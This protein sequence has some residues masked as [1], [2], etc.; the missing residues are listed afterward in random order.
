MLTQTR[1]DANNDSRISVR[2]CGSWRTVSLSF[3]FFFAEM[4]ISRNG[5][6]TI[7][8]DAQTMICAYFRFTLRR[9]RVSLL[10]SLPSC[11][12]NRAPFSSFSLFTSPWYRDCHE[13]AYARD[14]IHRQNHDGASLVEVGV[15]LQKDVVAGVDRD[16]Q[17]QDRAYRSD[18]QQ[19]DSE[20]VQACRNTLFIIYRGAGSPVNL[21]QW[22]RALNKSSFK[23]SRRTFIQNCS[24]DLE[25][26]GVGA[27]SSLEWILRGVNVSIQLVRI[28][29]LL[30][31]EKYLP[32]VFRE[33]FQR[34]G[35]S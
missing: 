26:A 30:H 25:I 14:R 20:I 6:A 10:V 29:S 16:V 8:P 22:N 15:L 19:S 11:C 4:L 27:S 7:F 13:T 18:G 12:R 21:L 32:T 9:R 5:N 33:Y 35:D 28:N 24:E 34:K 23:H 2:V 3:F 31:R 17:R 1:K